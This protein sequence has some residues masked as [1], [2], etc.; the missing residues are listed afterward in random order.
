M[1]YRQLCLSGFHSRKRERRGVSGGDGEHSRDEREQQKAARTEVLSESSSE[2]DYMG[3]PPTISR[4]VLSGEPPGNEF[5]LRV[6]LRNRDA[7]L[8]STKNLEAV[9]AACRRPLREERH[10]DPRIE[11]A[12]SA[13]HDADNHVRH[14]AIRAERNEGE[15]LAKDVRVGAETTPPEI[16]SEH[17]HA[18]GVW[19]GVRNPN[20]PPEYGPNSERRKEL[21]R[22]VGGR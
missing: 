5:K 7:G 8:E 4:W 19:G 2:R 14:P 22:N 3:A 17:H 9:P 15:P 16:V 11:E 6:G 21:G 18:R 12:K 1:S 13:W 20:A 10:P